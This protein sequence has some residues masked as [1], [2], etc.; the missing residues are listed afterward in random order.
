M[1]FLVY[2]ATQEKQELVTS[3]YYEKELKYQ[4]KI[5]A[6]EKAIDE[7]KIKDD[8][9]AESCDAETANVKKMREWMKENGKD[10]YAIYYID[11]ESY[12]EIK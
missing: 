10:Y 1:T 7:K 5:D 9:S 11:G 6:M 4:D 3:N 2:L 12:N 8:G